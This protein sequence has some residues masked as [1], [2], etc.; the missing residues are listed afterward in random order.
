MKLV[1]LG[2]THKFGK[3]IFRDITVINTGCCTNGKLN[4]V[5]LEIK[6]GDIFAYLKG[7]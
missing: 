3:F 7:G 4:Y 5:T 2:H 6:D 1:L